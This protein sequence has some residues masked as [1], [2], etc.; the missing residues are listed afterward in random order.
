M[1][2]EEY[3]NTVMPTAFARED[4]AWIQ[5]QLAQLP[6]GMRGKIASAYAQAYQEAF[7]AE[8]VSFRQENAAR[9]TANKRLREFCQRYSPAIRG[10][11]VKPPTVR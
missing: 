3:A 2:S 4:R 5:E 9:R 8:L 6:L 10:Y 1:H 7:D 11:T